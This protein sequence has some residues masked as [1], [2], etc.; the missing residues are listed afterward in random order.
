MHSHLICSH[1]LSLLTH[2]LSAEFA[3]RRGTSRC[4]QPR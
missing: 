3:L 2:M 4:G 1:C